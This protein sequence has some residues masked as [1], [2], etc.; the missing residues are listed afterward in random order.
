[1]HVSTKKLTTD[2]LRQIVHLVDCTNLFGATKA[3]RTRQRFRST[4]P[5]FLSLYSTAER[6][7]S[8]TT[9]TYIWWIV[10]TCL[11]RQKPQEQ[12]EDS[13][14]QGRASYHSTL[15]L[16]DLGHTPLSHTFPRTLSSALS[17]HHPHH[18][19]E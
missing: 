1:M 14:L 6:L 9:V 3:S 11:E 19:L 17:R 12:D 4:G 5:C 16:R 18:S 8:H 7:G 13:G 10:Q 15:Q 2:P